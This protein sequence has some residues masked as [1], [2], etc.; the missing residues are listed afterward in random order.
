MSAQRDRVTV[1]LPAQTRYLQAVRLLT[2]GLGARA[3]LSMEAVENL[4]TAVNEACTNVT[5]H[6]FTVD[7]EKQARSMKLVF[8]VADGEVT[9][10]VIDEGRGFDPKHLQPSTRPPLSE[11]GSLGLYLVHELMDEVKIESAPGSG[12]RI[13]MTKRRSR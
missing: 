13:I 7:T 5:E 11:D 10:E 3:D 1:S 4:K 8:Y 2:G 9:V 6:A 12:T